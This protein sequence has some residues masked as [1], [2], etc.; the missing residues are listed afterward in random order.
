LS[1]ARDLAHALDPV[2]FARERLG[3]AVDP[4]QAELV[5]GCGRRELLNCSRQWGKST[6]T[7]AAVLHEGNYRPGSRTII[8]SPG[9]RQ[10]SLLLAKVEEFASAAQIAFSRLSGDDPGLSLPSGVVIALPATE[11]TTRGF[12]GCTWLIVDEAS[13]VPDAVFFAALP[14]LATTNGRI[15]LL[16]TPFGQRGFY[17]R[18]H[19]S[20]RWNVTRVPA[21]E[22]SRISPAF[23]AEQ[24]LMMPHSWFRQEYECEFTSTEGAVFD[25]DV[26]L[27]SVS[28]QEAPLC[29]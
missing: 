3:L 7:A 28:D 12:S 16:S 13:R 10:S 11:A 6:T 19:E 18:E 21:A 20:G 9:Q 24:K 25:A 15:W 8:V 29:L 17:F 4:V 23:L 14:F 22:C 1:L 5:R 2:A 27:A 26:I